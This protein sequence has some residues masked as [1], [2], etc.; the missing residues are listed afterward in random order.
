MLTCGEIYLTFVKNIHSVLFIRNKTNIREYKLKQYVIDQNL[1][2]YPSFKDLNLKKGGC[3]RIE[4]SDGMYS[5]ISVSIL[6]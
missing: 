5:E 4:D 3:K 2:C 6:A 1:I